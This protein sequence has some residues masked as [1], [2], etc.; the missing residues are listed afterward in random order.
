MD[1]TMPE[2]LH[3]LESRDPKTLLREILM[4]IGYYESYLF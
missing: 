2:C 1:F 3:F 4:W